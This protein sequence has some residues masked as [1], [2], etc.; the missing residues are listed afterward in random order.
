MDKFDFYK[1]DETMSWVAATVFTDEHH[2]SAISEEELSYRKR[3]QED[4]KQEIEF[5]KLMIKDNPNFEKLSYK[6]KINFVA[7]LIVSL[8]EKKENSKFDGSE[9]SR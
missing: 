1:N 4:Y 3:L 8:Y 6:N 2:G 9:K 5:V 7:N